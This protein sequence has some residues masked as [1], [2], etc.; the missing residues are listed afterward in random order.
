MEKDSIVKGT[1]QYK[2][3]LEK[4]DKYIEKFVI[5]K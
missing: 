4:L 5:C 3:L 1:L 2:D